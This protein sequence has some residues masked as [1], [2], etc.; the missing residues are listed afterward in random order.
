MHLELFTRTSGK[1]ELQQALDRDRAKRETATL[2]E[3]SPSPEAH[4]PEGG[5]PLFKRPRK[6]ENMFRLDLL[7]GWMKP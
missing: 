2:E 3:L 7:N 4:T 6:P 1:S 5:K